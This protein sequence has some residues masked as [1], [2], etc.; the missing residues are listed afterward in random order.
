MT[1]VLGGAPSPITVA[2]DGGELLV[3]VSAALDVALT[4][5]AEPVCAGRPHPSCSPPSPSFRG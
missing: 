5:W 4:G 3:E 2:L 1:A